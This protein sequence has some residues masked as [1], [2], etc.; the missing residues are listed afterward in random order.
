MMIPINKQISE[1]QTLI[2]CL[3]LWVTLISLVLLI[4]GNVSYLPGF[5]LGAAGSALYAYLLY[6]RVPVLLTRPFTLKK[7]PQKKVTEDRSPTASLT[8]LWSGWVKIMQPIVALALMI[9][10]VSQ[11]F[12]QVSFPAALFGFFSFQISLFLYAILI[13]IRQIL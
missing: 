11:F 8:Y 4:S 5:L 9:L 2:L 12:Q 3:T 7:S 6:R 1:I 10:V 13:S